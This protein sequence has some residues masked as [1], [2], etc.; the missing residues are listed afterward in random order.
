M[1]Y[2]SALGHLNKLEKARFAIRK[3]EELHPDYI[4][5]SKTLHQNLNPSD[6][7][8]VVEGSRKAGWKG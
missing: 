4:S 8:H 3:C 2:A 5:N 1:V 7:E 6:T